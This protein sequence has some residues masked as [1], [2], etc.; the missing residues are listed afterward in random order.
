M[1][2]HSDSLTCTT[3]PI[4]L[5]NFNGENVVVR[6]GSGTVY[7]GGE[8]LTANN[9]IVANNVSVAALSDALG[10]ASPSATLN[11]LGAAVGTALTV[12]NNVI[13]E[14]SAV[15]L[16]YGGVFGAETLTTVLTALFDDGTTQS[17]NDTKVATGTQAVTAANVI[18][19]FFKSAH[20]LI[21]I[22]V[23]CR[24]SLAAGSSAATV[25]VTVTGNQGNTTPTPA[26][27]LANVSGKLYALGAAGGETVTWIA[28]S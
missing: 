28:T 17:V 23:A 15:S 13:R 6:V 5:D 3:S 7:V 2:V 8:S 26:L 11:T 4:L 14:V 12:P 22:S 19:T 10:T 20:N 1:G 18:A 24:S 25:A 21:S 16:T 27:S 9:G